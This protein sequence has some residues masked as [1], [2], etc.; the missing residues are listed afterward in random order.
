MTKQELFKKELKE[1]LDKHEVQLSLS[2]WDMTASLNF[3]TLGADGTTQGEDATTD[4]EI[5]ECFEDRWN[6]TIINEV[7]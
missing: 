2:C 5:A 6:E 1:L 3:H 4:N 7:L